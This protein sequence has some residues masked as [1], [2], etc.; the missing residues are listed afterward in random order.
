MRSVRFSSGGGRR[1]PFYSDDQSSTRKWPGLGTYFVSTHD[2]CWKR[3]WMIRF[4][5]QSLISG[6]AKNRSWALEEENQTTGFCKRIRKRKRGAKDF[7]FCSWMRRWIVTI[8][9]MRPSTSSPG[10]LMK[11]SIRLDLRDVAQTWSTRS[12]FQG[13][14][15]N[16]SLSKLANEEATIKELRLNTSIHSPG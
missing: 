12:E 8:L 16:E 1:P 6:C 2:R 10:N 7:P 4:N 5:S 14:R 13:V 3:S 9:S 11:C 15:T